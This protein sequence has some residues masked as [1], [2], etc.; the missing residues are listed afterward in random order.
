V[1][2]DG[3]DLPDGHRPDR[4]VVA[5]LAALGDLP[6]QVRRTLNR[7]TYRRLHPP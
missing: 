7:E 1:V 6:D 2:P 5:M 3:V 4:L